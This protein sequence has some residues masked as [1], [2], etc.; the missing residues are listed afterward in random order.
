MAHA[1]PALLVCVMVL[2]YAIRFPTA[3]AIIGIVLPIYL[4]NLWFALLA[5]R[6]PEGTLVENTARGVR[7][8]ETAHD[9]VL[10][11]TSATNS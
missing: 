5:L 9:S 10:D 7:F 6:K 1:L 8:Y 4:G 3:A 11:S 2:V